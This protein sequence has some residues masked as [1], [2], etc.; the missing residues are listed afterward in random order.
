MKDIKQKMQKAVDKGKEIF[1]KAL[2][3]EKEMT[4]K[5]SDRY[6]D[7]KAGSTSPM[8]ASPN[9]AAHWI[10]W[11]TLGF[12]LIF[13]LWAKFAVLE[14]VTV[15]NAT[16]IP[17]TH[18]QSIQNME[19][20]IVKDILV[21]ESD[22]VQKGQVLV[23]LD[24]TRFVS[25]LDEAKARAAALEIKIGRL[26]AEV[27][28]QPFNVDPTLAKNFPNLVRGEQQL[29]QSHMSELN[30][31]QSNLDLANKELGLTQPLV[32]ESAAS[33]VDVIHLQR[34]VIGL[35][36]Q[37]EDFYSKALNDLETARGDYGT[38]KASMV[39][40][41]DRLDRT[42][43]TSPVHGIV[44]QI[45][46]ST[47]GGVVLPGTEIMSIV[48]L[49]DT[50]LIEAQVTPSKIG[51]I[52]LGAPTLVKITAYDYSTYGGL[53]GK[54]EKISA[55]TITD[56]KGRSYYQVRIKTD[57]NYV[58]GPTD[59]LY[60]IPGMTASVNILT[61]KKTVLDYLLTPLIRAKDNALRE[62]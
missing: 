4:S 21:H 44:K 29:Y 9:R 1:S 58:R 54:V 11:C 22:I 36:S 34:Q 12:I 48:P 23:K 40:L 26:T 57:K 8:M 59:P 10:L 60:I 19:G 46:I 47:E 30:E 16:V 39:A 52:Y 5:L 28:K 24:P 15:A 33:E 18:V 25:A 37:I 31:M 56:P 38:L 20:G 35:K 50:L 61:G 51:F 6:K 53:T 43:I 62:R 49:E 32:K 3:R 17:L 41:Q 13:L 45:R 14:E 2:I 7:A 55:D 27:E 42:I